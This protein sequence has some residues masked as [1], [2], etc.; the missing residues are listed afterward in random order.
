[1]RPAR[2]LID[3]GAL[4]SNYRLARELGGGKALAIIKADAYG[5]GAVRCAQALEG[6]ADGFG[7]ATIEEALELRQA[8]IRAPILLLEGIFEPSDMALVAEHDFWFAVGS[9]WQVEALAAFDSPCPLTVW[10]KLDSGMHRLG[11]DAD[12]FRAAH[13]RLSALPQ[14]ERIVLMTHLAR[15]DELDSE[16]TREQ[17][18][19]FARAI[20]GLEG[21][22]SVCNSP[23]L[24]GWPEVRSD[25][26]RPGLMLYGAN[27]LPDNTVLTERLRPVMTMQSKVIAE[28]WIE[29][30]EPVGYGARF[31]AKAR[32][33]VG[34]VAL[35]Y[36]DGYPQFAP[37]GTPVLIDG[38]PG[39]LI[40]RVSMDMLT[41]D[42]TAHPQAG[43]GSVVE[44]WGS[45]PTLSELAPRCGVS[46]YQ[47]PC[48]VKRVAKVYV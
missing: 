40:G 47:L 10:L 9:P 28:R 31:V 41:V 26:V 25:W 12:S 21:E 37:N 23:A 7:V 46:A 30:G 43:I 36:A 38:Q 4:R 20:G 18:A 15:A 2:A 48:A 24:L 27:P 34:V 11:L 35:G 42:L 32:T 17:A 44:L 3:L 1:M 16:R 33:R 14:V 19:T 45:A 6:E 13:A 39:A 8:G 29:A 5:H 22:T